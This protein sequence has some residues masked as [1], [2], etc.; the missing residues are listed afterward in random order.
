MFIHIICN[1]KFCYFNQYANQDWPLF[2]R[3]HIKQFYDTYSCTFTDPLGL[4]QSWF[5][6]F[7]H[8]WQ[9]WI[10]SSSYVPFSC[11]SIVQS[12]TLFEYVW[13]CKL[14]CLY[15]WKQARSLNRIA[16]TSIWDLLF[17]HSTFFPC[18]QWIRAVRKYADAS[19][20]AFSKDLHNFRLTLWH[21]ISACIS[22]IAYVIHVN[23]VK[24]NH[25]YGAHTQLPFNGLG[26]CDSDGII[27]KCCSRLYFLRT[28]LHKYFVFSSIDLLVTPHV[29]V[30]VHI[31]WDKENIHSCMI[32]QY[33]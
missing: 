27:S 2:F 20:I 17:T 6:C 9:M 13:K 24:K 31:Q 30:F 29:C 8:F 3:R 32:I 18:T 26:I 15:A 25:W 10:V 11:T 4:L 19:K 21:G 5:M 28:S 22:L 33:V 14:L 7:F 16:W 1:L 12:N 23:V